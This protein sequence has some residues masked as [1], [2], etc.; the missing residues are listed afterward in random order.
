MLWGKICGLHNFT[1]ITNTSF[2]KFCVR[3]NK[4]LKVL[5]RVPGR[6]YP[7]TLWRALSAWSVRTEFS[8]NIT[9]PDCSPQ[10]PP[11][12]YS[13]SPWAARVRALADTL[14][15]VRPWARLPVRASFCSHEKWARCRGREG[16][17]E[18]RDMPWARP[19][20]VFLYWK[21]SLMQGQ[22]QL[23]L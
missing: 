19:T 23:N 7:Y 14:H 15:H 12:S 22:R 16:A 6:F 3:S 9:L 4:C 11:S 13:W 1:M 10:P 20:C 21:S 8:E 5:A 17:T 18:R 2:S